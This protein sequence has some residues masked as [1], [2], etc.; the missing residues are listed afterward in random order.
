MIPQVEAALDA[1]LGGVA[2]LR[3]AKGAGRIFELYVMT[4]IANA[5]LADGY[6][7]WLERS[8]ES[9]ILPTD[10]D[11]RFIQR[12][13]V[14]TGVPSRLA[15]PG[16]ASYIVFRNGDGAPEW[17]I[18]NGIAFQ[19]RSGGTHEIDIAIVSRATGQ[20]LRSRPLGGL[21]TGRPRVAVECKD[22]GHPGKV[23]EMRAF[24]ARLYDLSI[25][26]SH[27]PYFPS[28]SP[29]AVIHPGNPSDCDHNTATT[30]R[31][32]NKQTQNIIACRSG[33]APGAAALTGY[34]FIR[35]HAQIQVATPASTSLFVAVKDWCRARGY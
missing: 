2:I 9:K 21:P 34:H 22:V 3:S 16:N 23:D 20:A 17:E 13:G 6:Q 11:R 32:E 26:S 1:V 28:I 10:A 35:P 27:R 30:Y 15:G 31:Q 25:L 29:F 24:I 14:P 33:F 12:G 8:D 18:W 19:G 4:G 5:L 7:V